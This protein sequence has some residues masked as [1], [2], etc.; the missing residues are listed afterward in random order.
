MFLC[1][2]YFSPTGLQFFR[3]ETLKW[4]KKV[5]ENKEESYTTNLIKVIQSATEIGE[6]SLG[7]S[8]MQTEDPDEKNILKKQVNVLKVVSP[9]EIYIS[10][11]DEK[12]KERF[13]EMSAKLQEHYTNTKVKKHSLEINTKCVVFNRQTKV[14]HRAYLL[15]VAENTCTVSL[16]DMAEELTVPKSKVYV[17]ERSF[18][19]YPSFALKCH[20]YGITPAGDS[21]NWSHLAIEYVQELFKNEKNV[22]ITKGGPENDEEK[23]FAVT[24]W[25]LEFIP[26]GPLEPSTNKLNCVNKLL[27]NNGLALKKRN[28]SRSRQ[29][30]VPK[31]SEKKAVIDQDAEM[32]EV[33]ALAFYY[34][35]FI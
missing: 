35:I 11:E 8:E 33:M 4:D 25:Y 34:F 32:I 6:T 7:E 30:D 27:V 13:K 3:S 23:T 22:F 24:M 2:V 15:S 14:Y 16:M 31:V 1:N 9:S 17:L 28:L 5:P 18:G 10:F 12:I 21:K 26:G 29:S 19:V 20:L